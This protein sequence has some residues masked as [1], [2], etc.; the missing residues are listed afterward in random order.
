MEGLIFLAVIGWIFYK[1]LFGG[2]SKST[3]GFNKNSGER[4]TRYP[5]PGRGSKYLE[6]DSCGHDRF[7]NVSS[8]VKETPYGKTFTRYTGNCSKCGNGIR[9]DTGESS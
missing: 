2:S 9:Y 5:P 7:N 3:S 6:C 4:I 1:L 8:S